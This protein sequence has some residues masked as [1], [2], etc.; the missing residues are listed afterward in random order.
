MKKE[1]PN[2][3]F[4]ALDDS[5]I[6]AVAGGFFNVAVATVHQ[7]I[8]QTNVALITGAQVNIAANTAFNAAVAL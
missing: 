1:L 5:E 7:S 6:E 8:R 2:T 3:E 4:R